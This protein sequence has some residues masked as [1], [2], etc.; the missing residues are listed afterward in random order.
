MAVYLN[1]S[2]SQNYAGDWGNLSWLIT[3]PWLTILTVAIYRRYLSSNSDIP[4]PFWAS[5]TRFWHVKQ[6]IGGQQNIRIWELHKELGP[7]VRIAPNEISVSHPDA[8][9]KLL[10]DTLDK[11]Q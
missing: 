4:G 10:L 1:M 11:V 6:V 8:P 9:R 2:I 3:L 5:I 7:F